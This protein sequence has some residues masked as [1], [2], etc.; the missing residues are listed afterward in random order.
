MSDS[1]TGTA[2]DRR[3]AESRTPESRTPD[4]GS[5]DA[6]STADLVRNASEQISTLV[7]DEIALARLEVT[8]KARR[9]GMGAG[10]LSAALVASLYG[11]TGVLAGCV[12]L[13]ANVLPAWAA[14]VVV[15]AALILVACGL[16]TAGISRLRQA[17]PPV[18]Q[19][20]VR[21]VRADVEAVTTAVQERGH[22]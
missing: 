5:A 14:A 4:S 17:A 6:R 19:E 8:T 21:G 3:S 1:R 7:R 13:L 11:V 12:L 2:T 15:G 18:P 16:V 22:R 10:L 9:A 20:A